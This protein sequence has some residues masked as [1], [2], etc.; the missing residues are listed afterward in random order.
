METVR[1]IAITFCATAVFTSA[2]VL[3][4]GRTL[5]KSGRYIISLILLCSVIV[6]IG[7][8]KFNFNL[9]D[10][11]KTEQSTS[12]TFS[13]ICEYQAEYMIKGMLNNK[14]INFTNIEAKATKNKDGSI[15]INEIQVE[16]VA[17]RNAVSSAL[18]AEGIDCKVIFS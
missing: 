10:S 8:G 14:K 3:I 15:I 7:R 5:E 11:F 2:L 1:E 9:N 16:G 6:A 17:D 12:T 4:N 13:S 18:K